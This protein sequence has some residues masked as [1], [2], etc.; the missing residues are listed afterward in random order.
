MDK[1]R[2]PYEGETIVFFGQLSAKPRFGSKKG[3]DLVSEFGTCFGTSFGF[4]IVF[5]LGKEVQ[6]PCQKQGP[7]LGF[8]GC[9]IEARGVSSKQTLRLS[10][11]TQQERRICALPSYDQVGACV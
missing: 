10:K 4:P 7:K 5:L 9:G 6:N 1:I 8:L 2:H 11:L 3:P